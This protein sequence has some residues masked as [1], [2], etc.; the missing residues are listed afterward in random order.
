MDFARGARV[1]GLGTLLGA[2]GVAGCGGSGGASCA[3]GSGDGTVM[4]VV[5]GHDPAAISIAGVAGVQTTSGMVT[6]PARARTRSRP[7]R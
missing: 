2:A 5:T 3:P 6:V 1:A 7:R 4:L